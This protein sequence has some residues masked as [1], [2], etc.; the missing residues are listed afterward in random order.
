MKPH[1]VTYQYGSGAAWGYVLATS[2]DAVANA[3]PGAEIYEA[4]PAWMT[5]DDVARIMRHSTHTVAE[6]SADSILRGQMA[7]NRDYAS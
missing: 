5:A 4:P 7:L 1:L 3:V 2:S 6:A